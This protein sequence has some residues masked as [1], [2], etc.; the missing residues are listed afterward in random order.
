MRK[1]KVI[2]NN[3]EIYNK[4]NMLHF[5]PEVLL[6]DVKRIQIEKIIRNVNR[7]S[8]IL[9]MEVVGDYIILKKRGPLNFNIYLQS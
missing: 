4:L 6:K 2:T 1:N 9:D 5:S 3:R 8:K 7:N